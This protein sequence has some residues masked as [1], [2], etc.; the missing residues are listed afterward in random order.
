M[1]HGRGCA[2]GPGAGAGLVSASQPGASLAATA[3]QALGGVVQRWLDRPQPAA[4]V[5]SHDVTFLKSPRPR[6]VAV[7]AERC[8]G[9]GLCVDACPEKAISMNGVVEVDSR[10][11]TGCGKCVPECPTEALSMIG[12]RLMRG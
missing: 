9:C 7:D 8:T 10:L 4:T 11:C 3:V 6:P 2:R 12:P 1:G 5:I